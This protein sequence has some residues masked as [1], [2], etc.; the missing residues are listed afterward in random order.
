MKTLSAILLMLSAAT[1]S[2]Q[3]AEPV[4][5]T[6]SHIAIGTPQIPTSGT[7]QII[8]VTVSFR[9]AV[10]APEPRAVPDA[11]AQETARRALYEMAASECAALSEVFKADCRLSSLQILPALAV[12]A[13]APPSNPTMN[14]SVVYNLKPKE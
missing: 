6:L 2:A 12:P 8:R 7:D 9:T 3:S 13:N 11:K 5:G 4:A 14:A 10:E 1:A